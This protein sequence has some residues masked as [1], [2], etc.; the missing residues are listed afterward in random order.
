MFYDTNKAFRSRYRLSD[1]G[2]ALVFIRPFQT[3][4]CLSRGVPERGLLGRSRPN[5]LRNGSKANCYTSSASLQ[6]YVGTE[7]IRKT[8][9]CFCEDHGQSALF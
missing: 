9:L 8:S 6:S 3:S 7:A 2:L 1:W 5:T 4:E